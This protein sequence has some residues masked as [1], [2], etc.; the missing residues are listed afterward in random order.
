MIEART[1]YQNIRSDRVYYVIA[2]M[3]GTPVY[4]DRKVLAVQWRNGKFYGAM[5]FIDLTTSD[6]IFVGTPSGEGF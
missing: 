2:D 3:D 5:R 1:L 6:Y 4:R